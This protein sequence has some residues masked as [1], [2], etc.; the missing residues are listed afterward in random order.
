M[1]SVM[2]KH[3]GEKKVIRIKCNLNN[4][5]DLVSQQIKWTFF[6]PQLVTIP[7]SVLESQSD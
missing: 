3:T 4:N 6:K 2:N 7:K 1:V 5:R